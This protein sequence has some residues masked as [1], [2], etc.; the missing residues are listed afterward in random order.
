MVLEKPENHAVLGSMCHFFGEIETKSM[1][2][3]LKSLWK[4][5]L[6]CA[7]E[8]PLALGLPQKKVP[9]FSGGPESTSAELVYHSYHESNVNYKCTY[10]ATTL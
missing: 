10:L 8:F 5:Y 7:Y 1:S 4:S 2:L 6:R 3:T 9:A